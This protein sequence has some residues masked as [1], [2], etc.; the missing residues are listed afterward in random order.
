MLWQLQTAKARFSE[1]IDRACHEGPQIITRHGSERAV[2]LS[3]QD[4]KSLIGTDDAFKRHLLGGPK[5][6]E[7]SI[8][9][10]QDIGRSIEFDDE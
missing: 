4:Y 1:V 7:F 5:F 6:D 10:D 9:R 8:E 3:I 2:V